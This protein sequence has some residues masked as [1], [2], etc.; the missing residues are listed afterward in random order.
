MQIIGLL[1]NTRKR[2]VPALAAQWGLEEK[3][4]RDLFAYFNVPGVEGP[5][6][7]V[8]TERRK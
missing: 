3:V 1:E 5:Q 2:D 8:W 4:V 6:E 7:Q